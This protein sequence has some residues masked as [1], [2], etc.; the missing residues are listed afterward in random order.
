MAVPAPARTLLGPP[1]PAGLMLALAA[2]IAPSSSADRAP[3]PPTAMTPSSRLVLIFLLILFWLCSVVVGVGIGY[4]CGSHVATVVPAAGPATPD[5]ASGGLGAAPGAPA[6]RPAA[7]SPP[8]ASDAN[9]P[10]GLPVAV[11]QLQLEVLHKEHFTIGFD[12]QVRIPAWVSY[13]LG[14]PIRNHGHEHRPDRF[15]PDPEVNP[16]PRNEDYSRSGFDRGHMCPAFAMFSRFGPPGLMTTFITTNICPQLHELNAGRWEDLESLIA[17]HEG[18]GGGWAEQY[19]K[20]WVTDGPVIDPAGSRLRAG[21][22]VPTAFFM[23]VLRREADGHFRSLAVEMPNADITDPID[24]YL[25][26]IAQIER[27]TGLSFDTALPADEQE[28]LKGEAARSLW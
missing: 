13:E 24:R 12:P 17:G 21:E 26:P 25:V 4:Y 6:A 9:D 3:A 19:G 18:A 16:S 8:V 20:V 10:L 28:A 27:Q 14:G 5:A 22:A 1:P 2:S 11:P 15:A 23:I 7:A